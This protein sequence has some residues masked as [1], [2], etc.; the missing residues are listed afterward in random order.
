L[1][2]YIIDIISLPFRRL[3]NQV[4]RASLLMVGGD[5]TTDE[6]VTTGK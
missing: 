5:K 4:F 1:Y 6:L 2:A 3:T